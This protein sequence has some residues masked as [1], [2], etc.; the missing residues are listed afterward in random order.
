MKPYGVIAATVM[1]ALTLT[2]HGEGS[3]RH[4]DTPARVG[5][6]RRRSAAKS[7]LRAFIRFYQ[8]HLSAI[9]GPTCTMR[10]SCSDYG[11]QAIRKHGPILGAFITFDR[12]GR[13]HHDPTTYDIVFEGGRP[14]SHDPLEDNDFWLGK[15]KPKRNLIGRAKSLTPVRVL[16]PSRQKPAGTP[17]RVSNQ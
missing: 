5:D 4:Q 6:S 17:R 16:A 11:L 7:F 12:I 10:P 2:V 15:Q 8:K 13:I 14:Y 1:F 3:E 9:D